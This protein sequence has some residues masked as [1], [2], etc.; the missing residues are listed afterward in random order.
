[1]GQ[2]DLAEKPLAFSAPSQVI[3]IY[4]I[5]LPLCFGLA[6]KL[7]FNFGSNQEARERERNRAGGVAAIRSMLCYYRPNLVRGLRIGDAIRLSHG[8]AGAAAAHIPAA[9]PAA[10][11]PASPIP[12]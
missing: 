10:A 1:M 9:R 8:Y 4:N 11:S 7:E 3:F 5:P 2:S 12:E 6:L